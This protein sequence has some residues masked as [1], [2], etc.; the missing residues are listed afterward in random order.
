MFSVRCSRIQTHS[1][2]KVTK[3][4]TDQNTIHSGG[5][6]TPLTDETKLTNVSS[7]KPETTA[8]SVDQQTDKTGRTKQPDNGT[9]TSEIG[10]TTFGR[11]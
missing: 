2:T 6:Q 3:L 10:R 9:K 11:N 8:V 4:S 5:K 7:F 1:T